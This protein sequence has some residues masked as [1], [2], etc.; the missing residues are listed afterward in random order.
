MFWQESPNH[1]G[2]NCRQ[3]SQNYHFRDTDCDHTLI[4]CLF[5]YNKRQLTMLCIHMGA[6]RS[7]MRDVLCMCTHWCLCE[8][9]HI[10]HTASCLLLAD[11][12]VI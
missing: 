2:L 9:E 4:F 6:H 11:T 3:H 1:I 12:S 7:G 10:E 5:M 8:S